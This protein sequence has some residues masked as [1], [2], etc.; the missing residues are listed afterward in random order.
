MADSGMSAKQLAEWLAF[1]F[2]LQAQLARLEERLPRAA[3]EV[4]TRMAGRH[5]AE[6]TI[7]PEDTLRHAEEDVFG[8]REARYQR[9][10]SSLL[11]GRAE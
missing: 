9:R 7:T 8:R 4:A 6:S 10:M 11:A 3:A 1:I 5:A 2:R